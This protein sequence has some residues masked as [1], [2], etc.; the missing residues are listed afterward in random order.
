MFKNGKW[1]PEVV[2]ESNIVEPLIITATDQRGSE[3]K[4]NLTAILS[5][6]DEWIN[7]VQQ[8]QD[9]YMSL[10]ARVEEMGHCLDEFDDGR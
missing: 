7:N 4:L 8:L 9:A 6:I 5:I 3:V 1:I 2:D 10:R